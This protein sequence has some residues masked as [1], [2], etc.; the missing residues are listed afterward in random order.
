[1]GQKKSFSEIL[2]NTVST[3]KSS[4]WGIL[5][6]YWFVL[7]AG[8]AA[9]FIM[10]KIFHIPM[11]QFLNSKNIKL[12]SPLSIVLH[13]LFIYAGI[14]FSTWQILIIKNNIF[15]GKS[16]LLQAFKKAL[17]KS[18]RVCLILIVF[19]PLFIFI[20]F[21]AKEASPLCFNLLPFLTIPL[22]PLSMLFVGIIL[23][24]GKFKDI[25][26]HSFGIC[27]TYYFKIFG[28]LLLLFILIIV[29][30]IAIGLLFIVLKFLIVFMFV[31]II[32]SI[33][34]NIMLNPFISCFF[35]E[36]YLDLATE[37]T[38]LNLGDLQLLDADNIAGANSD[39]KKIQTEQ[40]APVHKNEALE[41][42]RPLGGDY[43][44]NNNK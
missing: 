29:G 24:D 5:A 14:L 42:M 30:F 1:M 22:L 18:L 11:Q 7:A 19:L 25:L 44:D 6:T 31:I 34:I 15:S 4:F 3:F 26:A 10:E 20:A 35:V 8:F 27:F 28:F 37:E 36:F 12:T 21:W 23:E 33:L 9:Y 17:S 39:Y 43:G 32:L 2:G 13:T 16:N 38:E 41:G 40:A